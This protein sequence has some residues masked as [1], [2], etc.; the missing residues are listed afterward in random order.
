[1][2][3]ALPPQPYELLG[4]SLLLGMFLAR[5]D[6]G[7]PEPPLV[8]VEASPNISETLLSLT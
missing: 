8:L 1:M 5:M 4:V 7:K 3:P 2:T 6:L